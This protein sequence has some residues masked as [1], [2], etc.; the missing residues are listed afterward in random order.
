M[1]FTIV[2]LVCITIVIGIAGAFWLAISKGYEYKHTVDPHP[3][4]VKEDHKDQQK[5]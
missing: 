5:E 3:D 1:T 4:D 2:M